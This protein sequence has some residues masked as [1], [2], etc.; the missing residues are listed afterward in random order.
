M[1]LPLIGKTKKPNSWMWALIA[2][3]LVVASTGSYLL[4]SR[5]SPKIDINKLTV[6]VKSETIQVRITASGTVVPSQSVN[7]S[8]KN[9]GIL[10][11]LYVQQGS[12]VQKGQEIALMENSELQAQVAQQLA[13]LR[14]AEARLAAART[15]RPEEITQAKAR[16]AQAKS[17]LREAQE[18]RPREVEQAE[19]Q[20]NSAQ[21]QTD[22][23]QQRLRRYQDLRRDGAIAQDK[24]DEV[25]AT[26][27]SAQATQEQAE[28]RLAQVRNSKSPQLEQQSANVAQLRS[29]LEQAQAGQRPEDIAQLAAAVEGARAA[30]Q[31][32]QVKLSDTV[33]RAP[34]D[35]IVTQKYA[36]EGAFVT[37]TT[38]ASSNGSATSTSIVAIAQDLEIKA[39]VPEV[40]IGR[41]KPG[42]SVE[43]VADAYS[44]KIFKGTVRLV[45]PEAV[46]DQNVTSFEVRVAIDS[47]KKQLRSGMNVNVTFLGEQVLNALM[48]P[49][50]AIVT[51][52]GQTGVLIPDSEGNP[53]FKPVKIGSSIQDKT[54]IIEGIEEGKRVFIDAPKDRKPKNK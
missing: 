39:K 15:S 4:L 54:Q 38:S 23:A 43:I 48:V 2:T 17:S 35:G 47:G 29:A 45:A 36:D 33:I 28:K 37:P 46:V 9:A 25:E 22:L 3:G 44:D 16:L 5:S 20:L 19:A 21:A 51:E 49:T 1:E 10:A 8:P 50:V 41:I 52:K 26:Y 7:L 53:E 32:I 18:T 6:P 42:Q 34:F 40:D 11:K 30:L 24:L 13:S 14:Q 31:E 27:R 12:S